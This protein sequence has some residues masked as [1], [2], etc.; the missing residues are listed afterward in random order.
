MLYLADRH[1]V[2]QEVVL[3][4]GGVVRLVSTDELP[5]VFH[6]RGH[7]AVEELDEAQGL[8]LGLEIEIHTIAVRLS[9]R[10]KDRRKGKELSLHEGLKKIR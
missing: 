7:V 4:V 1:D 9:L 10:E 8:V 5:T 6:L 2:D 3:E